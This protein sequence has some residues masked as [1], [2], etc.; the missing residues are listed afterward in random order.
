[1]TNVVISLDIPK[2][3]KCTKE[4]N[5]QTISKKLFLSDSTNTYEWIVKAPVL[6][7]D[8]NIE[9][10]V[11]VVSDLTSKVKATELLWIDGKNK[12]DNRLNFKKDT[13]SFDNYKE[14]PI[15][16]LESDYNALLVG[17]NADTKK[18]LKDVI[19]E[20]AG[21]YC[22]G[23]AATA[24]LT[25][26]ERLN[27]SKIDPSANSLHS[28]TK[29]DK[30]KSVIGYYWITQL[31]ENVQ[32]EKVNFNKNTISKKLTIIE[33]KAKKVEQGGNPF[34][35]SFYTQPNNTGGHAVVGYAHENGLFEW[36]DT[37]Y[38]SR[39]LIYDSNYPEFNEKS[40]LYYKSDTNKWYI[41][42][43][44]N[45]SNIT[46]ALSNLNIMDLKNIETNSKA[47][48]SYI[49]ARGNEQLNI[50]SSNGSLLSS[51]DGATA[52]NNK[53]VAFRNDGSDE[54]LVIAIPE[55]KIEKA[56]TI[57]SASD[58]SELNLSVKYDN[59]YLVAQSQEQNSITFNPKGKVAL[60][61]VVENFNIEITTNSQHTP[62]EWETVSVRAKKGTNPTMN[63]VSDGYVLTG[64]ELSKISVYAESENSANKLSF[65]TD[66]NKVL[67]TQTDAKLCVKSDIGYREGNSPRSRRKCV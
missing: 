33:N 61:G 36:N 57:E 12:N 14:I 34:I 31:F 13:W 30:A 19:K 56:Y 3:I 62:L 43:Y 11:S 49:M 48:N 50:Y 59:C 32:D 22:Y 27:V 52:S 20:N 66:K 51:V 2:K 37:I 44:P 8:Q 23:M 25:K 40:C 1:M 58:N 24:V 6:K 42:N 21:G 65:K 60:N 10:S 26:T 38:D 28:I 41:P 67:I 5:K 53:V 55:K 17:L 29:T 18:F 35:L 15:P 64:N 16:L 7:K 39:I 9:Y 45:S 54:T 47:V 63:I 46:R 4:G